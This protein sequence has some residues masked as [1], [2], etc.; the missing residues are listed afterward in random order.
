LAAFQGQHS[1]STQAMAILDDESR[2]FITS[3]FVKLETLTKPTYN[4]R[5]NEVEFMEA[6]FANA[7]Q[8]AE[9]N[10]ALIESALDLGKAHGIAAMDSLHLAAAISADADEF[11]TAEKPSKPMFR[12]TA[13]RLTSLHSAPVSTEQAPEA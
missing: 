1:L 11:V 7:T 6:F 12:V 8:L 3:D 2:E 9:V 4:K 10:Q 5:E 13:I